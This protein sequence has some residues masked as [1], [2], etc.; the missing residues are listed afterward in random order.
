MKFSSHLCDE[1]NPCDGALTIAEKKPA[2]AM[3]Y[4]AFDM[5]FL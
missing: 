2:L 4:E 1:D 3:N 5:V